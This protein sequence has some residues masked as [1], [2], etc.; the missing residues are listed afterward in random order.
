MY[1][2]VLCTIPQIRALYVNVTCKHNLFVF[3]IL[4]LQHGMDVQNSYLSGGIVLL[5]ANNSEREQTRLDDS[6]RALSPT[7]QWFIYKQVTYL[8]TYYD[9]TDPPNTLV[10]IVSPQEPAKQ[11]NWTENVWMDL[12]GTNVPPWPTWIIN[13][14]CTQDPVSLM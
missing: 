4:R 3:H 7:F 2:H 10:V 12:D 13:G 11:Q 9:T 14:M 6:T 1:T 8:R 5:F